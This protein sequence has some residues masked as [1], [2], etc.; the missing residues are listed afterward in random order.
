M[1]T[2]AADIADWTRE[3]CEPRTHGEPFT[4]RQGT[5]WIT[6]RHYTRHPSLLDQLRLAIEPSTTVE[7]GRRPFAS[8]PSAR[9]EAIDRLMDIEA[10]SDDW[11]IRL[12]IGDV[13]APAED[14]LHALAGAYPGMGPTEARLYARD[15]RRW[16]SWAKT[17][18]G[19][20]SPAWRP[21]APCPLCEAKGS[22]R[23]R[24]AESTGVCV[25]CGEAWD[26]GTIGL[27]ADHIRQTNGE[28]T[29][30]S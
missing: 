8:K 9:L 16:L 12:G 7:D 26:P 5:T 22:L 24:L 17:V 4:T 13:K 25:E 6:Q 19:W 18:T 27:L 11:V 2:N 21:N 29:L 23:V 1:S 14:N 20:D 15:L 3:L 28:D 10:Q 30:V